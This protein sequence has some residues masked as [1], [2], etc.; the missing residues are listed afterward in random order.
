MKHQHRARAVLTL[1][2]SLLLAMTGCSGTGDGD[3]AS[4][5]L[6]PSNAPTSSSASSPEGCA[7]LDLEQV[8]S[9]ADNQ[10][11]DVQEDRTTKGGLSCTVL[12]GPATPPVS[13]YVLAEHGTLK[14]DARWDARAGVRVRKRLTVAGEPALFLAGDSAGTRVVRLVTHVEDHLLRVATANLDGM[15]DD[16]A[17][18]ERTI[19]AVA[20]AAVDADFATG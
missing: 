10:F 6:S 3:E 17:E 2:G 18:M 1:T 7:R 16:Q 11:H 20:E 19:V 15:Y 12:G 14:Q 4:G 9:G 5:T 8:S 13:I